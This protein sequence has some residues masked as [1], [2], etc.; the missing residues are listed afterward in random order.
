MCPTNTP[1]LEPLHYGIWPMISAAACKKR[2]ASVPIMKRQMNAAWQ[3]A[4]PDKI[5]KI[6]P[7]N[8]P[9]LEEWDGLLVKQ[10]TLS[11]IE[12]SLS[13]RIVT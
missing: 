3:N 11:F 8:R 2:V 5:R 12:N 10:R 1:D 13:N 6:C 4:D 7:K 9:K